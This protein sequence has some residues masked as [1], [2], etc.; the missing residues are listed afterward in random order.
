M[1]MN[2]DPSDNHRKTCPFIML[3][4]KYTDFIKSKQHKYCIFVRLYLLSSGTDVQY[5]WP[6]L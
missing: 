5:V 3:L 6:N 4:S 2:A 1:T